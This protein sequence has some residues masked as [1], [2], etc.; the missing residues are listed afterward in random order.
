M[1]VDIPKDV[2]AAV[3]EFEP[4]TPEIIP[5]KTDTI[6]ESDIEAVLQAI[7]GSELFIDLRRVNVDVD[8]F[9]IVS[10]LIGLSDN[11]VRKDR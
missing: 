1:L 7:R 6:R 10:E 4:K 5:R 11:T 3:T 2:T 8:N 9:R